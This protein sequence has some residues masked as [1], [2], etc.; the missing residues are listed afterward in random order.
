MM[1]VGRDVV[2]E[3]SRS[4]NDDAWIRSGTADVTPGDATTMCDATNIGIILR[5]P[6]NP[7]PLP[8]ARQ[9]HANN[10]SRD[11][12][13]P[14]LFYQNVQNLVTIVKFDRELRL[15]QLKADAI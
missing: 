11:A 3:F 10:R 12:F 6:S 2:Y 1:Y 15:S 9:S 7:P 8:R 5:P 4:C 13:C 14:Q